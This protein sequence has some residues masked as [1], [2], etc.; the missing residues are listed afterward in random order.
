MSLLGLRETKETGKR[1]SQ[2]ERPALCPEMA[3]WVPALW[4]LQ[5]WSR[6]G[7]AEKGRLRPSAVAGCV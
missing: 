6:G 5:R 7:V 4:T 2:G 3:A 1:Q